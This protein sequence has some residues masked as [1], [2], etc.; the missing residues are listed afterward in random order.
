[1]SVVETLVR[2]FGE[3]VEQGGL[4]C[5]RR[6]QQLVDTACVVETADAKTLALFDR[7]LRRM[8]GRKLDL[9]QARKLRET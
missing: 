4:A 6:S 3:L 8:A 7:A 1:M 9:R 2:V 5:S